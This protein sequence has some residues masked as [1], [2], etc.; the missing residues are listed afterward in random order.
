MRHV[1]DALHVA[2]VHEL[3]VAALRVAHIRH[4]RAQLAVVRATLSAEPAADAVD[5]VELEALGRYAVG[6]ATGREQ[7]VVVVDLG[8]AWRVHV[9]APAHVGQT[10]RHVEAG[11]AEVVRA[12]VERERPDAE[13]VLPAVPDVSDR[14][15]RK[16]VVH[17][18]AATD[19]LAAGHGYRA[20]HRR[21]RATIREEHRHVE[22]ALVEELVGEVAPLLKEDDPLPGVFGERRRQDAAGRPRSDDDDVGLERA[23]CG[24]GWSSGPA[25]PMTGHDASSE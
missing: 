17:R 25:Y 1:A 7:F 4:H 10:G 24:R 21:P 8:I 19:A 9:D 2:M 12:A 3:H 6:F 11:D 16:G 14:I 18:R 15:E 13:R 22:L 5:H 23:H 20:V